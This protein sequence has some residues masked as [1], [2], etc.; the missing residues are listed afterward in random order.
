MIAD[1]DP[2][3]SF[4]V[5]SSCRNSDK[6]QDINPLLNQNKCV[7]THCVCLCVCM[8]EQHNEP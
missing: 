3:F 2:F 1:S 5:D 7:C 8:E 4:F 6:Y